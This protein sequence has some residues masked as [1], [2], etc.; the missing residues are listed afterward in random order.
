MALSR[1]QLRLRNRIILAI[2][3]FFG[4]FGFCE[5]APLEAWLGGTSQAVTFQFFAYLVPFLIGGYD[6]LRNAIAGIIHRQPFDESLL[7]TI[8]TLGAFAMVAFPDSDPHMA[9]GAAVMLFYQ[10]GELFQSYA[11]G[12]SR[13]SIAE[14]MDITPDYA[15]VD[16]NGSLVQVDPEELSVGDLFVVKPGERIP[17]D[18]VIQSGSSTLDTSA[19]TGESAPRFIHEGQEVASGCINLTGVLTVSATRIFEE[20]TVSRILELVENASDKKARTESFITRF[21]RVY[22]PVVSVS[23]LLLALVPPILFGAPWADWVERALTFLVVSCPCALVISVPLTF[24]G[25]IGGASR[26]GVLVKGGNYLEALSQVD[27][28]VFDKTGTLT[29]GSFDVVAINPALGVTPEHLLETAAFA[30]AFS[31][32]PIALSIKKAYG[33][34]VSPSRVQEGRNYAGA[35][36]SVIYDGEA[37][38][39]G[40]AQLME[41]LEIPYT[42]N[43]TPATVVYVAREGRFLGSLTIA[44]RVKDQARDAIDALHGVQVYSCIMLTGD[45]QPVAQEVAE[46]LSLDGY[47]AELLPQD[48]VSALEEVL[49]KKPSGSQVAFVGDGIN[50]APVLT[51]ADVGIAMGA[52]GSDAAIEAADVVLMDDDPS[53]I[54][55]AIRIARKT[56]SIARE[57]I[58]FAL[59]VKFGV[60]G[61]AA[62]GLANMWMAVFADVGVAILAILNAMRAMRVKDLVST[63]KKRL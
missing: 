61:L 56:M 19:L 36:V 55:L 2:A 40:N 23:A 4:V 59:G 52:L 17:L 63:D 6:V 3:I 20:S 34:E 24:F 8:A 25:G 44:D 50:D 45:R 11:V 7:M 35:G 22:T 57:N 53:K 60:L 47:Q 1:A 48:K 32:H 46:R 51:R 14:M 13:Q 31:D 37:C 41:D 28:V 30:E 49:A 16:R 18:G 54:A 15:N 42:P 10:V 9:E 27:T 43:T 39:A 12:K 62:F 26:A 21:A 33:R 29:T 58:V 38:L 5:L